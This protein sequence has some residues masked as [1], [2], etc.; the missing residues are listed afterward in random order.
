MA[1]GEFLNRPV[2]DL[3]VKCVLQGFFLHDPYVYQKIVLKLRTHLRN[4]WGRTPTN[5][6]VRQAYTFQRTTANAFAR[7]RKMS[8]RFAQNLR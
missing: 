3:R 8:A 6:L 4:V 7:I 5:V 1:T 2:Q